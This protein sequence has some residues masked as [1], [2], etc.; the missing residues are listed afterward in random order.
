MNLTKKVPTKSEVIKF[1]KKLI[2][3]FKA[4]KLKNNNYKLLKLVIKFKNK[5]RNTKK[6]ITLTNY[7]VLKN[8]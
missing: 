3:Y 7:G 6:Q 1:L 8:N 5:A 4:Q 2:S